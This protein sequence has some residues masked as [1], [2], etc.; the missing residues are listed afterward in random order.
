MI[1]FWNIEI[2]LHLFLDLPHPFAIT[3]FEDLLFWTDWQTKSI[4]QANKFTGRNATT[5]HNKLH[6]PM[7][8]IV[9]HPLRQPYGK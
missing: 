6:F 4:H 8:L 7:D 3:V 1:S 9:V 5:L 2:Q